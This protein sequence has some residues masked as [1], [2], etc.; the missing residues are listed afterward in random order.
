MDH[1]TSPWAAE[2]AR[3]PANPSTSAKPKKLAALPE[4]ADQHRRF[5]PVTVREGPGHKPR[6]HA[7]GGEDRKTYAD[8]GERD[9]EDVV[10]VDR[11]EREVQPVPEPEHEHREEQQPHPTVEAPERLC[12][13][14]DHPRIISQASRSRF[15][16][17]LL[18]APWPVSADF[19]V[20][21]SVC[22]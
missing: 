20:R 14:R 5:A 9:A 18:F 11:A 12:G 1:P 10:E 3:Y 19:P 15:R 22:L 16:V 2:T 6:E 17:L 4:R 13:T 21:Y 8:Q 7:R